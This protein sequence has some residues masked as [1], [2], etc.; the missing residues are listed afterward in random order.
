M[1]PKIYLAPMS[2]VTDLAF[3]LISRRL[4]ASHCFFEML[5]SKAILYGSQK[6]RGLIKTIKKDSPISAQLLG[7][8]PSAMLDAAEKLI[9]LVDISF[10]DINSACPVKKVTKKGAGAALLKDKALLGKIIKKLVSKLRIPVTVKLRTG[11]D[12]RDISEC[13]RIAEECEANGASIVFIHGRTVSQRYS[14]DIDYESIK[15]AKESLKIPVFG[16]GNIFN[17]F[18]AKKM[19]DETGCNGILVA[20]G[21]LGN[22]WIFKNIE[23]YLKNGETPKNPSLPAKKKVLKAHLAYIEKYKD[24]GPANK[25]G[26]MGKITMWYFK[27]HHNSKGIRTRISKVTSYE[28]LIGLIES[29]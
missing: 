27:G 25:I 11:F 10:L 5:D 13:V 12:K 6:N 1:N 29:V 19:L 4:G 21:A 20:R 24:I 23:N 15:A 22:P 8:D 26:L 3:R 7:A 16:S 18:M 2:G 14:G 9:E 28:E 17:P